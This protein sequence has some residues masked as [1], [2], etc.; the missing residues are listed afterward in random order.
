MNQIQSLALEIQPSGLKQ[1]IEKCAIIEMSIAE[2]TNEWNKEK[3]FIQP[4]RR[5]DIWPEIGRTTVI[6]VTRE[7]WKDI[8]DKSK[9]WAQ[10]ER[11][12]KS[13]C[14]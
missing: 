10:A 3:G 1:T 6:S 4:H 14:I 12:E 9:V 2:S 8:P 11:H 13:K 7:E 5:G